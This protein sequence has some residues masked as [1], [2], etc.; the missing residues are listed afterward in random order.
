MTN[1]V[2]TISASGFAASAGGLGALIVKIPAASLGSPGP[3][4]FTIQMNAVAAGAAADVNNV[5]LL[6]GSSAVVI[7]FTP[8]AGIQEAWEVEGILDGQTAAIL[9]TAT[10]GPST[11]VYYATLKAEFL[12]P[13]GGNRRR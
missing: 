4:L 11:I 5:E 9:Q 12:G 10:A 13:Y 3:Y 8:A 1:I 6:L 7:P 2:T